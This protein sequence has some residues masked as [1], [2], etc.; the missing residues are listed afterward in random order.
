MMKRK[1][2]LGSLLLLSLCV[3]GCETSFNVG[4][5]SSREKT[6]TA[7]NSDDDESSNDLSDSSNQDE[8]SDPGDDSSS[9][10]SSSSSR[11]SSSSS[12]SRP[13]SSSSS[14]S[15]SRPS[16]SSS[17]SSSADPSTLGD[18]FFNET[19][20]NTVQ[21]IHTTD[22]N[23]YLNFTGDYYHITKDDLDGFHAYGSANADPDPSHPNAVTV[24]WDYNAPSGKSVSNYSFTYGQKSDLTDGYTITNLTSKQAQ[25]YNPYLGDNYFQV[26]ANLKDGTQEKS[27]IKVFK[28]TTQA[29][30]N[31]KIG[32][33]SNCRDMG[34]RTTYA[35]GKVKQGLIYRT[36]GS[37]YNTSNTSGTT[38]NNEGKQVMLDQLRVKTE[39]NVADSTKYNINL[40]GTTVK[41]CYMDYGATPYSNFSRNAEKIRQVF[42]ILADQNNYPV[43]YH[44]RIGTDR[45]GITG[46][47]IGGL[48]GIPFEEVIQD[49]GFSN[50]G[51]IGGQRYAN[52]PSDPDGDDC[53]KYVNEL[54]AMPGENFQEQTYNA[55]LS[56]G[57]P[58]SKLNTIINLMTE[59]NKATLP[60][61]AKIG[62][63]NSLST[64][65]TKNSDN[66]YSNPESYCTVNSG[67][68]V[69]F[70]TTT[71]AG[72]KKIVAYLGSLNSNKSTKLA[73]CVS[74][75]IDNQEKTIVDKTMFLAGFGQT[76]Q[77]KRT[78]Y[79]F[80]ILGGYE[81]SAGQHT[82]TITS[83]DSSNALNVG[84]ICVFDSTG[85][86]QGGGGEQQ[87]SHGANEHTFSYGS[88]ISESNKT[89]YKIGTC[90]CG[91]KDICWAVKDYTAITLGTGD[92][93]SNYSH[94]ATQFKLQKNNTQLTYT[95]NLSEALNGTFCIRGWV[96]HYNDSN[97][98]KDKGFIVNG[99][100]NIEVYVGSTK[101]NITNTKTYEEMGVKSGEVESSAAICEVGAMSLEKGSNTITIKRLGSYTLNMYDLHVIG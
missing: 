99:N 9:S 69:S 70:T 46:I 72:N 59:G 18:F 32:N 5:H 51:K 65:G 16:S 13:S 33:L 62:V 8:S 67:G 43:F 34:G 47:L 14:S 10:S 57:I 31:L 68:T 58:A 63:G 44:C 64:S 6:S 21:D 53:A 91:K 77:T 42:D 36:C 52:K 29:P 40:N 35:G 90:E 97:N 79:M 7:E 92:S 17:S 98:N 55:L 27:Q 19:E 4:G 76:G 38:I 20:L 75:K 60:D 25:F 56:I 81:L 89:T 86:E 15:S 78:G 2:F 48:L 66:Q 22:Q 39:I 88:P 28:V 93:E 49:Y 96:D 83:K 71:T 73:D 12:S 3:A 95:F 54:L 87:S 23:S 41:N 24:S 85:G 61:T 26:T 74:L 84:S 101:V 37:G 30:R 82:F 80:N 100:P 1:L 94:S 11:P 50:F 45:T